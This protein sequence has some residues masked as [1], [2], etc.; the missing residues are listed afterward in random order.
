MGVEPD[1]N[2]TGYNRLRVEPWTY[3][4]E[5][6]VIMECKGI[7]NLSLKANDKEIYS[8]Y[9]FGYNK[10]EAEQYTGLDEFLTKRGYRLTLSEI[11]NALS[12]IS[13]FISSGYAS[14]VT[15]RVG[16]NNSKDWRYDN[17]TFI[18]CLKRSG[19]SVS[20]NAFSITVQG[21]PMFALT[22]HD[23]ITFANAEGINGDHTVSVVFSSSSNKIVFGCTTPLATGYY[24]N[25]DISVNGSHKA[26]N[27]LGIE[28]GNI[29]DA[30]NIVDPQSI[31]N[32]RISPARNAMRWLNNILRSYRKFTN[33]S[34][35]IFTDGDGNYFAKFKLTGG[36]CILENAALGESD[37]LNKSVYQDANNAMPLLEAERATFDFPMNS[38]QY[39]AILKNPK[40]KIYYE[41]NSIS[42]YGWI[43][44]INYVPKAGLATF[45][46]IPKYTN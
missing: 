33:D 45:N 42:G 2:R 43:D 3:F 17:D 40:G 11:N 37:T 30:E 27:S 34:K 12:K 4:Y 26:G 5:D 31:Y 44:T 28:L 25:V 16:N 21:S 35:I 9:Q 8:T 20:I 18:Y 29:E 39:Q 14:E 41:D 13:T 36:G 7:N 19:F 24:E 10:W 6:T 23:V 46:L 15:R 22:N 38:K 32:A 1:T